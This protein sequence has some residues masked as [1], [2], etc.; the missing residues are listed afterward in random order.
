MVDDKGAAANDSSNAYVSATVGLKEGTSYADMKDFFAKEVD[1]CP[2]LPLLHFASILFCLLHPTTASTSQCPA[3]LCPALLIACL[4]RWNSFCRLS[5]R[6]VPLQHHRW[7]L[8]LLQ[9]VRDF[10][11]VKIACVQGAG[12]A[13]PVRPG[14]MRGWTPRP[15]I[16]YSTPA[17]PPQGSPAGNCQAREWR[18]QD[19]TR[20][21][22]PPGFLPGKQPCSSWWVPAAGAQCAACRHAGLAPRLGQF[23]ARGASAGI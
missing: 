5:R 16:T 11:Q 1:G 17:H 3:L 15:R 6:L 22:A 4:N 20:W 19:S 9:A 14:R 18:P 12:T 7:K 10:L 21:L 23:Q 8:D 13:E 2:P